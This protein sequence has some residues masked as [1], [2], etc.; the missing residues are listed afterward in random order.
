MTSI[1][2][3]A[4]A[5]GDRAAMQTRRSAS[6]PERRPVD[7]A[8]A[9]RAAAQLLGA[10]GAH[11]GTRG[12]R[13]TLRRMSTAYAEMLTPAP[14]NTKTFPNEEGYDDLVVVRG[15]RFQSLCMRHLLPF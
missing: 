7:R 13:D 9:E 1:S 10:L 3:P 4:A 2:F 5:S 12:L 8:A 15:L 11:L 14:F 6:P